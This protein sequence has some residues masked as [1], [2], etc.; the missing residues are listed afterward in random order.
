MG[1][2]DG[3]SVKIFIAA[4][5]NYFDLMQVKEQNQRER[6]A[7]TLLVE[8]ARAWFKTYNYNLNFLFWYQLLSNILWHFNLADYTH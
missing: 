4:S 3:E 6:Y 7:E 5:E 2:A 8:K 1:A